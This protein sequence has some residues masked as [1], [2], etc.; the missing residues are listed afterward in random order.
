MYVYDIKGELVRVLVNE[1]QTSGYY[2]VEFRPNN[3]ERVKG[4]LGLDWAT[5]YNDD[6]ASGIYIYQIMVKS[7][8]N[9]PVFTDMNKMI[10]LK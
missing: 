7:D 6:V 5:G 8:R 10:L 4:N 1:Y 9:I 2:E 3:S